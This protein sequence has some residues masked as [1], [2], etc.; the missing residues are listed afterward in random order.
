MKEK[1]SYA[2]A[3]GGGGIKG[4][5]QVGVIKALKELK[6]NIDAVSGTSIGAI[7]AAF[8]L[9]GDIKLMER[10]YIDMDFYDMCNNQIE[11]DENKD[12]F[13]IKNIFNV[14]KEY[15]KNNGLD[16]SALRELLVK[17]LN[18]D[19]V[20]KS[21]KNI[22]IVT[23]STNSKSV[24]HRFK[25]DINKSDFID[26]ILAS[27]CFPI[28][29][30]Q[31]IRNEEYIDGGVADVIPIN[32]LIDKG[33]KNIIAVDIEGIGL[34][35]SV[36]DTSAHVKLIYSKENLGGMFEFNKEQI[37]KNMYKGYLDTMRNFNK[38][39]G[40]IYYFRNDEF[41]KILKDININT[42]YG[43]E[44]VAR[45]YGIDNYAI[46]SF[47]DFFEKIVH[48]HSAKYR[49]YKNINGVIDVADILK[50]KKITDVLDDRF[51]ICLFVDAIKLW[52]TLLNNK[53]LENNFREYLIGAQALIDMGY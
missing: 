45:I 32:M 50:S 14:F 40:S 46:Y 1:T 11:I 36:N 27:A 3:L 31:K 5:Y 15:V 28:F 51:G 2:L 38:L 30:R 16:N 29:K 53:I 9:Q 42:L 23:Y 19:K 4:A 44:C 13:D 24:V 52:P 47:D 43:L 34:T 41:R 6:I 17:N 21:S 22:G 33:Y 18:V 7:N 26:Y 49:E 20:Y 12:L 8:M 39:Q 25:E 48:V 10:L 37:A 35:K